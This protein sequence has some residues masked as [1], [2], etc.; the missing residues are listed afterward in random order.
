MYLE[1]ARAYGDFLIVGVDSD[2]KVRRR[3]GPGGRPY[4]SWSGCAW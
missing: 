1:A 4:P 2:E 3:K